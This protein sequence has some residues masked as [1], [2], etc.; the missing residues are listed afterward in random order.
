MAPGNQTRNVGAT[1]AVALQAGN[2]DTEKDAG[3]SDQKCRGDPCGRRLGDGVD[4]HAT[5]SL[6]ESISDKNDARC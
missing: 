4:L 6:A 2:N 3:R 1:L 5:Y